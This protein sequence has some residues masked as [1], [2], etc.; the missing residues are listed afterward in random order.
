VSGRLGALAAAVTEDVR[1]RSRRAILLA[2][3]AGLLA[4]FTLGASILPSAFTT[5]LL[6]AYGLF[7]GAFAIVLAAGLLQ[8]FGGTFGDALA[9]GGWSRLEAEA[10]WRRLG[11]GRIP[12][13][14][15]EALKW[16]SD[17]PDPAALQPQRLAALLLT[18]DVAGARATLETYPA[19]TV[20]ERFGAE[21]DRWALDFVEGAMPDFAHV[22][23]LAAEITDPHHQR[24]AAASMAILRAHAAVAEGR[25]WVPPLA[26]T[27]PLVGDAADG[28]IGARYVLPSWT[29]SVAIAALLIGVALLF[30]RLTGVWS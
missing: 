15:A 25:D 2:I 10:R 23:A 11:A 14:P 6:L 28:I 17:H 12:R 8:Q 4:N 18:N 20:Y 21:C 30:G 29:M 16:L 13:S 7:L 26:A 24:S 3:G 1:R 5:N 27:R 22:E 19:D 9:V